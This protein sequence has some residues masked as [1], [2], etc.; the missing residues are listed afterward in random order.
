MGSSDILKQL[1]MLSRTKGYEIKDVC[2]PETGKN[3]EV[4]PE[5]TG[6]SGS[7]VGAIGKGLAISAAAALGGAVLGYALTRDKK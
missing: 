3:C 1:E 2:N 7:I 6:K 4:K 5:K